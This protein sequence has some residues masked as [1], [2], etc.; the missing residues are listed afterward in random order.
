LQRLQT[1]YIDLYQIHWPSRVTPL[2]ETLAALEE[3]RQEGKVRAVGVCN[4]GPGDLAD[5]LPR[6][7][8]ETNQLPYSLLWRAIE[9]EIQQRCFDAGMGILCYSPLAQGL[10]TGK[11]ASAAEVPDGRAR[12]RLFSGQRTLARHGQAGQEE[13]AFAA[14]ARVRQISAA[15]GQP[16]A[17]VALA[18]LL[19][20]PGVTSVIAGA[21][22]PGQIEETG[23]A[24]ELEL[25]S[26]TVRALT[27]ATTALKLKLGPDPDMWQAESRFR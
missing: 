19:H 3:L 13:E 17:L 4:F 10:L 20:Q 16:M 24:A 7:W 12:T 26:E 15:V 8:A 18:W 23:R 1:D 14:I 27:E 9:Y 2:A 6:G 5:L 25:P 22:R 21:R 11:F